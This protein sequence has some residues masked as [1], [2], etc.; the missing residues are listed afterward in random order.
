MR[1][2]STKISNQLSEKRSRLQSLLCEDTVQT[3][4][5]MK[6]KYFPE[7]LEKKQD[8]GSLRKT[9]TLKSLIL[10]R[11]NRSNNQAFRSRTVTI[12]SANLQ[13]A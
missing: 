5:R 12:T 11:L 8:K 9:V 7:Y 2:G 10:N 4:V 1:M 13:P 3:M 6:P